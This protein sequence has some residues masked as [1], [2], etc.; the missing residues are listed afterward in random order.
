MRKLDYNGFDSLFYHRKTRKMSPK[1]LRTEK[2]NKGAGFIINTG[3]PVVPYHL[4]S[5]RSYHIQ[6]NKQKN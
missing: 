5:P 2:Q 1:A 6:S 4:Y 3:H